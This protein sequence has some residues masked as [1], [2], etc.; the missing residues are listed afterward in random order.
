[1]RTFVREFYSVPYWT[2][3]SRND[4]GAVGIMRDPDNSKLGNLGTRDVIKNKEQFFV[5]CIPG[6]VFQ[7]DNV[8]PQVTQN[9][10]AFF[11]EQQIPQISWHVSRVCCLLST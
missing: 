10:Q 5:Q 3:A 1:M 8:Y 7:Q 4:P 9:L 11:S 6:G 2:N